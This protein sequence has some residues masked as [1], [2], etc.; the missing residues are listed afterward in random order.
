MAAELWLCSHQRRARL[1]SAER[2]VCH[3]Q[4]EALTEPHGEVY[5]VPAQR[6]LPLSP[7]CRSSC[8]QHA[9]DHIVALRTPGCSCPVL[10]PVG[11]GKFRAPSLHWLQ[12]LNPNYFTTRVA[13]YLQLIAP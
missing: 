12:V 7:R 13:Y 11:G 8:K 1:L 2:N 3:P 5:D 9:L 10:E 6:R 4:S